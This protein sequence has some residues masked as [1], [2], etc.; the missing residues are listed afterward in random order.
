MRNGSGIKQK[1]W[2]GFV[3]ESKG[4]VRT[5]PHREQPEAALG[6][7]ERQKQAWLYPEMRVLGFVQLHVRM[8]GLASLS[9]EGT[10]PA[11]RKGRGGNSIPT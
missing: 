10:V 11:C 3:L 9:S 1:Y 8:L 7:V 6:N 2:L 5:R 4:T